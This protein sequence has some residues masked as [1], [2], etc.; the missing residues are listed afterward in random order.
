MNEKLSDKLLVVWTSTDRE[1]ALNMVLMYVYNAQRHHW[2]GQV[3]LLIWGPS[4]Q[5]VLHDAE[6][7]DKLAEMAQEGVRL[8]AC[9]GCADNY[10]IADELSACG[11][12]VFGTGPTLTGWLKSDCKVLTF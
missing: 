6:V 5:L 11:I 10:G 3:T 9:R 12:E 4:Q 8:I 7:R 1:V 2:W